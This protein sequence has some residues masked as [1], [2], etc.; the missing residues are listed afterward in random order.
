MDVKSVKKEREEELV[1]S[2]EGEKWRGKWKNCGER[3]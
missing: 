3:S 1:M 2:L